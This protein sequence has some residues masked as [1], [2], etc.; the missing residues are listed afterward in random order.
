MIIPGDHVLIQFELV[1]KVI[2][3]KNPPDI[4]R[5]WTNLLKKYCRSQMEAKV[6]QV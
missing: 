6:A 2:K 5:K 1:M 4:D 3:S